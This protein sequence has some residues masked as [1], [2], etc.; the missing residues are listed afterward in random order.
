MNNDK[1]NQLFSAARNET[2]PSPPADFEADVLRA[3]QREAPLSRGDASLFDQLNLWFPKI[4][5]VAVCI[6]CFCVAGEIVASLNSPSLGDGVAELSDQ[7]M[8]TGKGF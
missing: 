2:P 1:L 4:A 5:W 6:I 7:W 8:F 3:I